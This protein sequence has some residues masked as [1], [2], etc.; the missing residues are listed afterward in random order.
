MIPPAERAGRELQRFEEP[1]P[2]QA[3]PGG[4]PI[5]LPSTQAPEGAAG[6]ELVI[7]RIE[8]SGARSTT[9]RT[10]N[11]CTAN[12]SAGGSRSRRSTTWRG[13]SP[14]TTARTATCSRAPSFRC[15]SWTRRARRCAWRWSRAMSARSN[16]RA[17]SWPA[18]GISSPTTR[19]RSLPNGRSMS[20]RWSATCCW[21]TTCRGCASTRR[22]GR[23]RGAGAPP[24]WSWRSRK[25]RSMPPR[26]STIAAPQARGPYQFLTQA[27]DQQPAWA[28]TRR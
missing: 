14:P 15:R 18:T 4:P 12:S 10:S 27:H 26:A 1:P 8:I 13:G 17:S 22:C 23:R 11:R 2:P 21:P 3:R 28:V 16:G 19:P 25:S 5:I 24:S 9:G 7:R 20:A 6:I